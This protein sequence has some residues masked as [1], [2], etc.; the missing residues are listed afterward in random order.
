MMGRELHFSFIEKIRKLVQKENRLAGNLQISSPWVNMA[1]LINGFFADDPEVTVEYDE[2]AVAVVLRVGNPF[3]A[4][5][6]TQV[7]PES[8]DFGNVKLKVKVVP[9]NDDVTYAQL[10]GMALNGNPVAVEVGNVDASGMSYP[11]VMFSPRVIQY[12]NDELCHPCGIRTVLLEQA[13]RE[14]FPDARDDSFV[15]FVSYPVA[16]DVEI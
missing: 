14:I 6:L 12:W 16:V 8:Y 10:L 1:N 2:D 3:K 7:L 9:E 15:S 11:Y 4:D 13:A 5:A